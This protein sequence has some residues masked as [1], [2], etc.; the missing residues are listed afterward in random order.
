MPVPVALTAAVRGG[1]NGLG[2]IVSNDGQ[3]K[4]DLHIV[5]V[6]LAMVHGADL[7][8]KK[9]DRIQKF[10]FPSA[11]QGLMP[12]NKQPSLPPLTMPPMC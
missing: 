1:G 4:T 2:L 3:R 6:P 9:E 7:S 5:K 10:P 12:N 8:M 11:F